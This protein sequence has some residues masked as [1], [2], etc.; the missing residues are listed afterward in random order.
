MKKLVAISIMAA[1]LLAIGVAAMA[2]ETNWQI[3]MRASNGAGSNYGTSFT[4]GTFSSS[5]DN[6][7]AKDVAGSFLTTN[8]AN[9]MSLNEG[10]GGTPP[11]YSSDYRAKLTGTET[12][13]WDLRLWRMQTM[14]GTDLKLVWWAGGATPVNNDPVGSF[15]GVAYSYKIE[16]YSDPTQQNQGFVWTSDDPTGG[17]ATAGL[18]S[19]SWTGLGNG[20]GSGQVYGDQTYA[21]DN[22]IKIRLTVAPKTVPQTPEP[23]SML[24]LASG[25]FGMAGFAV[26]RRK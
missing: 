20:V 17:A 26:R 11:L 13:V 24:A 22:A 2:N 10:Y 25:L 15:G 3:L 21:P 23:S 7:E 6:K 8:V 4:A 5:A 1:M 12:Q 19:L 14:A 18:G 9:I 16:V